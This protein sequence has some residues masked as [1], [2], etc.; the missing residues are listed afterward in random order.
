M[1]RHAV[2]RLLTNANRY[3]LLIGFALLSPP[4][5][6]RLRKI[7]CANQVKFSNMINFLIRLNRFHRDA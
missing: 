2:H 4:H 7:S 6:M 5:T 3:V 1:L